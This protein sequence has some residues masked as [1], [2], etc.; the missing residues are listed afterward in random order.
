M[1]S[2]WGKSGKRQNWERRPV[3]SPRAVEAMWG[4]VELRFQSKKQGR[5]TIR[6]ACWKDYFGC[7][8]VNR[9]WGNRGHP[10][11]GRVLK[12]EMLPCPRVVAGEVAR[13]AGCTVEAQPAGL[14][15]LG[16]GRRQEGERRPGWRHGFCIEQ[17]SGWWWVCTKMGR[18]TVQEM[19]ESFVLAK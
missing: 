16:V 11:Y 4:L 6:S 5:D 3:R 17:P 18:T 9:L 12:R 2:T 19:W 13:S 8:L 15:M 7:C 10:G 14:V 1:H